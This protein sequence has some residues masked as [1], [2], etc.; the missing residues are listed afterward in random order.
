[1]CH[2]NEPS[3]QPHSR[4]ERE[5]ARLRPSPEGVAQQ[6]ATVSNNTPEGVINARCNILQVQKC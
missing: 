1:M 6:P 5:D 3:E 2:N 4:G